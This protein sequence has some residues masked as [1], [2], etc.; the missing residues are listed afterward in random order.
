[1]KDCRFSRDNLF[2]YT[3]SGRD[4]GLEIISQSTI[5]RDRSEMSTPNILNFFCPRQIRELIQMFPKSASYALIYIIRSI[6]LYYI[7]NNSDKISS[8]QCF[9][10]MSLETKMFLISYNI[11]LNICTTF[12]QTLKIYLVLSWNF[13][14]YATESRLYISFWSET[15]QQNFQI[16]LQNLNIKLYYKR[17]RSKKF[18]CY[19]DV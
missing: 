8:R 5:L 2:I 14:I 9:Y 6:H 15:E 11:I 1:M 12:R 18:L 10:S 13:K 7:V 4:A 17:K 19:V 16:Q 3:I